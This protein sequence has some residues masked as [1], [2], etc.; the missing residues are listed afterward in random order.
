MGT[1]VSFTV[2][3]LTEAA[4]RASL[5][6]ACGTLHEADMTFSTWKRDSPVSR[7]RRGEVVLSQVPPEVAEVLELC[8]TAVAWSRGWFDPWAIPGGV[9]PTGLVK[10]WAVERALTVLRRAG[11]A[12]ALVNGGG[13]LAVFGLAG[14]GSAVADR[15]PAPVAAGRTGRH[16]RGAGRRGHLGHV[17]AR[18]APV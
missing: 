7:L 1:V 10:G 11:A 12:A 3:G 18:A 8:R 15:H 16:H 5:G 6:A 14:P 9:D 17:R 4:A 2:L 13:D